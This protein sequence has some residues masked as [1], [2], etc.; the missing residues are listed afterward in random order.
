M[1]KDSPIQPH[2]TGDDDNSN[3]AQP[4]RK[5]DILR[6][7]CCILRSKS[8]G[9]KNKSSNQSL[10]TQDHAQVTGLS[11][12]ASQPAS[13]PTRI[14]H[15]ASLSTSAANTT[16]VPSTGQKSISGIFSEDLPKP[17]I[18]T[19]LPD[20]LDLIEM[21]QQLV[22]TQRLIRNGRLVIPPEAA[23]ISVAPT[24]EPIDESQGIT[25]TESNIPRAQGEQEWIPNETER[26]WIGAQDHIQQHHFCELV[27]NVVAEFI[28]DD[29]KGS[30]TIAEVVI[31]GPILDSDT[32]RILLNCLIV[33]CKQDISFNSLLLQGLVQLI[34]DASPDYLEHGDL[35]D[36]L[37][38]LQ[39]SLKRL[40]KS[41]S[42]QK[43]LAKDKSPSADMPASKHTL[44]LNSKTS[45]DH[46][47]QIIIAISRLLNVMV[48]NEVKN[49]DRIG[50]HQSLVISLSELEDITDPFLQFQI[51]YALQASQ[52]I[53]DDES[54][55]QEILR[56]GGN[57]SVLTLG[58]SNICKLDPETLFNNLD[59]LREAA[60]E[61]HAVTKQ[62]PKGQEGF[63]QGRSGSAH[64]L[65]NGIHAGSRHEWYL[66]LLF[67]RTFVRHGQLAKFN[68]TICG[69]RCGDN[70]AFQLG[71]CQILGELA[72]DPLWSTT[73]RQQAV[74]FLVA[75]ISPTIGW[76]QHLVVQEWVLA[77]LTQLTDLLD[78]DVKDY[79]QKALQDLA[80]ESAFATPITATTST[81]FALSS[82]FPLPESSPLLVRAQKISYLEYDLHE[83]RILRIEESHQGIYIPPMAKANLK[84][85]DDS[86]FSLIDKVEEFLTSKREVMLILG[87]SGAGKST[88]NRHLE[89]QLWTNYTIGGPIP[90]YINLPVI[91]DPEEDMISKQL[92][93][94]YFSEEHIQEMKQHRE[95]ILICDG[96]D[97][98]Q[99]TANLHKSNHLNQDDQ[100]RAKMIISCRTQFLGPISLDQFA[101]Q[102][103]HYQHPTLGLFQEAVIVPFSNIQVEDYVTRYVP[104]EPRPWVIGDYMRMLTTIPNL[105]DLVRNPFL[106]TL[107]LETL[108]DITKGKKNL[109]TIKIARVQ[110][111]DAFVARWLSVNKRRLESN[112]LS[113]QDRD[114]FDQLL[115]AGFVSMGVDYSTRL[116][117]EIFDKQGGKLVVQ[118]VQPE[119]Q[120]TW[121][122]EFFGSEPVTRLLR[123]S[124]PLTRTDNMFRFIHQSMLDPVRIDEEF[125]VLAETEADD[126]QPLDSDGPLFQ[127]NLLNE[128]SIMFLCDRVKL[129]HTFEHQLRAVIDQSKTDTSAATAA[130]NA[131]TILNRASVS[132][133]GA[134]LRGIR[135]PDADLSNG[136]FDSVQFQ[137]ADLTRAN[138]AR[139]WLRQADFS[140]SNLEDVTFGELPR[141]ESEGPVK[142]CCF[143]PNGRMLAMTV[144]NG[145]IHV[146][147]TST[148]TRMH[149]LDGH[150]KPVELDEYVQPP[151]ACI[152]QP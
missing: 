60:E 96:Y 85:R 132:F 43:E 126:H 41:S 28:K 4:V 50:V 15:S 7:L 129:H 131:I 103:D 21:T 64:N 29:L 73:I 123:E 76:K 133:N 109:S 97:E 100:W 19:H 38:V 141:L 127:R 13:I 94:H 39:E 48:I 36:T 108:P 113:A 87:D 99:L 130:T 37:T 63:Q 49:V 134:D 75:L 45:F 136:Q 115:D 84:A 14:S 124:S 148:W 119:D 142:A 78:A 25:I 44:S 74:D 54:I 112:A 20:A 93:M 77:I 52:Y 10:N 61:A 105:M 107:A 40:H 149:R 125:D 69:A 122:A 26:T 120:S 83:Y 146:Y 104:L 91:H 79:V 56:F 152:Q 17:T 46:L 5:R 62:F 65:F 47:C 90:L 81:S 145:V 27:K 70:Q 71:V 23:A 68:R 135:I 12:I 55:S 67:A 89:H 147:D 111:Y 116:A 121:K 140:S 31:L 86:L 106:L 16:T 80:Q 98:S 110:L 51:Q 9:L 92:Q 57:V 1:V 82:R 144:E 150:V 128:P 35:V 6:S 138:L 24:T 72:M 3:A 151:E 88:F 30:A 95:F 59:I 11:F 58:A 33:K 42:E 22:Y 2:A 66:T 143:S 117:S 32:Y 114:I 118:Y 34:E 137:G 102:G 101:P 139:S 18:K 53:A 8:K